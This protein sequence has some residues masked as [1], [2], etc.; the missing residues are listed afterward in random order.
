[1]VERC[2]TA[3]IVV[4]ILCWLVSFVGCGSQAQP[5]DQLD[6]ASVPG[7][8][9]RERVFM[10]FGAPDKIDDY[11]DRPPRA[12][13]EGEGDGFPFE[14]WHYAHLDGIG[15]DVNLEFVDTCICG[16]Y[17]LANRGALIGDSSPN[18]E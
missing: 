7:W 3:T 6:T 1:M 12:P 10:K 8:G 14:I 2:R 9:D 15:D 13:D 17:K 18:E 11:R 5:T 4:I 16:E